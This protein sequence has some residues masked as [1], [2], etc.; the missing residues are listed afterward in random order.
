MT[1]GSTIGRRLGLSL[2][3]K[4]LFWNKRYFTAFIENDSLAAPLLDGTGW[5]RR[6]FASV[7]YR[8]VRI[9]DVELGAR[10][11][12][13]LGVLFVAERLKMTDFQR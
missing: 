6:G 7:A 12:L 11:G 13:V 5:W 8:W 2:W 9:D 1:L 10:I 4:R 3:P